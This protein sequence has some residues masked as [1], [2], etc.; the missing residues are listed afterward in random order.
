[1]KQFSGFQDSDFPS[2]EHGYEPV[3]G[4]TITVHGTPAGSL[5][6]K[7]DIKALSERLATYARAHPVRKRTNKIVM[8]L[9]TST[10][11]N[12]TSSIDVA[13]LENVLNCADEYVRLSIGPQDVLTNLLESTSMNK[14]SCV[15]LYELRDALTAEFAKNSSI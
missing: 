1:M 9:L 10:S 11:T 4:S 6:T 2:P 8:D 12:K 14:T 13:E 5:F 15:D 3:A 7:S